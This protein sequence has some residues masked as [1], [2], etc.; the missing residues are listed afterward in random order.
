LAVVLENDMN[1][2][3]MQLTLPATSIFGKEEGDKRPLQ[4]YARFLAVQNPPVNPEQIV[5]RMKFDMKSESP[6]LH[7]APVRWL[8]DDEYPTILAKGESEEAK[9]A[10]NMTVA[11]ADGVK[12]PSLGLAGKAPAVVKAA[13]VEAEDDEPAPAPKAKKAAPKAEPTEDVGEP[14]VRKAA[15]KADAVPAQKSK[16]A[17]IVSDWDDE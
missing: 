13:P 7:F 10:V 15:P 9:R 4:A 16:L 14:E 17:S 3:I 2:E 12:A 6:K 8:T 11:Q 1:G 5:T